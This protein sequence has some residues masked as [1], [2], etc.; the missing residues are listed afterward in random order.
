MKFKALGIII[1]SLLWVVSGLSYDWGTPV[2]TKNPENI[3]H[4]PVILGPYGTDDPQPDS[5]FYDDGVGNYL[6]YGPS[7]IWADVRFTP[8]DSFEL[9]S[10]YLQVLNSQSSLGQGATIV[11]QNNA[12][13]GMPTSTMLSDIVMLPNPPLGSVWHDYNFETPI[14]FGPLQDFH[15]CYGPAPAGTYPGP[16]WWTNSDNSGV[17]PARSYYGVSAAGQLPT[18]WTLSSFGDFLIRAGGEYLNPFTDMENINTF[19]QDKKFFKA[20]NAEIQLK[21]TAENIGMTDVTTFSITWEV[22]T[23]AG[24]PVFETSGAYGPL[25][26]GQAGSF[27]APEIW[28]VDNIGT[29]YITTTTVTPGDENTS[30]DISYLEQYV[31]TLENGTPYSY[32]Q[33]T[34]TGSSTY[35]EWGVSFN[36]P[37]TATQAKI[38][39]FSLTFNDSTSAD[40]KIYLND[41]Y[42]NQPQTEVWSTTASIPAVGT[43]TFDTEG[44]IV[45]DDMFTMYYGGPGSLMREGGNYNASSN[46]SMMIVSWEGGWS[47]MYSGDWPFTVYLDTSDALPPNPV[48]ELSDSS[49]TFGEVTVGDTGWF[50]LTVYNMGGGDNLILTNA[51]FNPPYGVFGVT[52]F[53]PNTAITAGDSTILHLFFT[54]PDTGELNNAFGIFNNATAPVPLIVP[55]SGIGTPLGGIAEGKPSVPVEYEL[56]QNMPNPFNPTTTIEFALPTASHVELVVYNIL[57]NEIARLLDSELEAGYHQAVF[58]ATHLSSG[59]YFYRLTAGNHTDMKKMVLMK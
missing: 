12:A 36:L 21:A 52:N 31:N 53:V 28:T 27:A 16:G 46:D 13:N 9:R 58:D 6:I 20:P 14:L 15:I 50:D 23:Q 34:L 42:N 49:L 47:K 32:V 1:L 3:F 44:L 2:S 4:D 5:I 57:G 43:Y 38:D 24:A 56:A 10:V 45:F 41:G 37:G 19:T 7:N 22:T 11:L 40:L 26:T 39:S 29:Y 8:A 17:V 30:N 51:M 48:I 35:F 55:V 59:I 18:S 54:P 33:N 25:N